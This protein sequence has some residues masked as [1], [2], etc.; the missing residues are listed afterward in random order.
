MGTNCNGVNC[1]ACI[2]DGL[3]MHDDERSG[4]VKEGQFEHA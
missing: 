2:H 1:L 3:S 4:S